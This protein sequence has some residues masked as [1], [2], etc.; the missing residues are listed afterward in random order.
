VTE[1]TDNVASLPHKYC[2]GIQYS[3]PLW[4][5]KIRLLVLHIGAL[6]ALLMPFDWNLF[7]LFFFSFVVRMWAVEAGYHRYFSHRAFRTSR[8]F[9]ALLA[10]LACTTGQ[11]G[12]IWWAAYH[13]KHHQKSEKADDPYGANRSFW[14]AHMGWYLDPNNLDTDLDLV[15]D[16]SRFKELRF[17]N[18]RYD[19]AV[20][21]MALVIFLA[22][23][24]G[25]F[26]G[27]VT[28]LSALLWGFFLPTALITHVTSAI[29][30]VGHAR[31][32][33]GGYRRFCTDDNSV[34]NFWLSL[35]TMGG[36]WHNNHHRYGAGA[37]AGLAWWEIDL[38]YYI[39]YFLSLF[40][41]VWDLKP[42][43]RQVYVD[44]GLVQSI[45]DA[46]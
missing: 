46:D 28:G 20:I 33:L 16:L 10:F 7:W 1:I 23:V 17:L 38:S 44:A 34:N 6:C 5:I 40:G 41:I 21:V 27:N 29:N 22:G 13:R 8:F 31:V 42:I 24:S 18:Q 36:G 4:W 3:G 26:G 30:S 19:L 11:R 14:Y 12:V 37:C 32:K 35:L 2:Y 15:P 43:P 39:L 9:Q 45:A 25:W